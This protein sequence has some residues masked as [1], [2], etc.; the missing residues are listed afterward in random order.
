MIGYNASIIQYLQIYQIHVVTQ[1]FCQ[2][3]VGETNAK[4][5]VGGKYFAGSNYGPKTTS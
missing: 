2:Q 3:F 4:I 1:G 5:S